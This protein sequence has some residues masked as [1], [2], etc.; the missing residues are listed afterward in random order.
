MAKSMKKTNFATIL[1]ILAANVC[2]KIP[3]HYHIFVTNLL[4][5]LGTFC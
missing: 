5:N 3:T 1:Q 4:L 2:I